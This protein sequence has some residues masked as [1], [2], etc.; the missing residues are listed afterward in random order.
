MAEEPQAQPAIHQPPTP[1]LPTLHAFLAELP[2]NFQSTFK[3]YPPTEP[4]I[5]TT[6]ILKTLLR[7][8][9]RK[10]LPADFK[11]PP[12]DSTDS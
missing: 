10:Q 5:P 1:K 8:P 2:N 6:P 3:K 4:D 11:I 12:V 7:L 9:H